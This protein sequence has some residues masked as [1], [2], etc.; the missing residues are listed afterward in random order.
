VHA[1]I[2]DQILSGEFL[3]RPDW[4]PGAEIVGAAI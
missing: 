2:I 3:T 4:A 1:E